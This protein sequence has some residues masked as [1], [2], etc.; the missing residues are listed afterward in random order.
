MNTTQKNQNIIL[1]EDEYSKISALVSNVDTEAADL[2]TEELDRATIVSRAE[3]PKTVASMNS[4][5]TYVDIESNEE[6]TVILVYPHEAN[7]DEDKISVLAPMGAALIGLSVGQPI[8]WV[9][10]NGK[11]KSVRVTNVQQLN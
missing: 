11:R 5:I 1:T 6:N 4:K 9:L 10:P 2:L 7:I 8:S 3:L